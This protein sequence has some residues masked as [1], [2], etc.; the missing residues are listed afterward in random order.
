MATIIDYAKLMNDLKKW[1]SSPSIWYD[2]NNYRESYMALTYDFGIESIA[3][4]KIKH[5]ASKKEISV[6]MKVI[7]SN[8]KGHISINPDNKIK[9]EV[10][11][12]VSREKIKYQLKYPFENFI[13]NNDE[14]AVIIETESSFDFELILYYLGITVS[15]NG[16]ATDY[17]LSRFRSAFSQAEKSPEKLD[18]LYEN[19]LSQAISDRGDDTLWND[20]QTL[21]KFDNSK[22][23]VDTGS[24]ILNVLRG[25]SDF[26]VI[27]N[28]FKKHPSV[29]FEIYNTI[30]DFE[31]KESFCTLLN[32]LCY[33]CS[34]DLDKAKVNFITGTDY[35]FTLS[36]QTKNDEKVFTIYN[37]KFIKKGNDYDDV[38]RIETPS[39]EIAELC[40]LDLVTLIDQSVKKTSKT[41]L[42]SLPVCAMYVY[43]MA[44]KK[45]RENLMLILRVTIDLVAIV[46]GFAS[47]GSASGISAVIIGLDIGLATTDLA[48]M[49]PDVKKFIQDL[50]GGDWF[51]ENW[52]IIYTVVGLGI[53][54]SLMVRGIIEHAPKLIR[55]FKNLKNLKI[56]QRIFLNQLEELLRKVQAYE[57]R[58]AATQSLEE[59]VILMKPT[60][61]TLLKKI[62]KL[63]FSN[64]DEFIDSV[65]KNLVDKGLSITQKNGVYQVLYKGVVVESG[66]EFKVGL[67]LRKMYFGSSRKV[68]KL[69]LQAINSVTRSSFSHI[70]TN[71]AILNGTEDLGTFLVGSFGSDLQFILRELGYEKLDD[72]LVMESGYV[73][74]VAKGQKFNLLDV[75][76]DIY[77]K[78]IAKG[79]GGFFTHINSKWVDAAVAQ[80]AE[81][82]VMSKTEYLYNSIRN[83]YGEIIGKKLSGFGKE[84]HRFE[85]KHGY[86]FDVKTKRMLSP[87]QLKGKKISTL[88]QA[89]DNTIKI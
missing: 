88:T 15:K 46:I 34:E 67:F 54:T 9:W 58:I 27:Y 56:K 37:K 68:S 13:T 26:I 70:P 40:P 19:A 81:V 53:L 29:A 76:D 55:A 51:V 77:N 2:Y 48:L 80:R 72:I 10:D 22:W 69:L 39:I 28:Y 36:T 30:S 38:I 89:D 41:E 14:F 23:F 83:E 3:P 60:S 45:K 16:K 52:D 71:G 84:I 20:L 50:P 25:F 31:N 18:W 35:F 61:S 82:V 5:P 24:A 73:F 62:L 44:E 65:A 4:F 66:V 6:S 75:S 42:Q 32:A 11:I 8:E 59:V 74:N 1:T 17:L 57:A 64:T 33:A 87:E 78:A 85:W 47:L 7:F 43:Y 79:G 21:T 86:R 49:H 63:A 12:D